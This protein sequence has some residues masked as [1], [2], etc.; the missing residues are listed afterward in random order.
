MPDFFNFLIEILKS[1]VTCNNSLWTENKADSWRL[2]D[3]S[4]DGFFKVGTIVT[5][6]WTDGID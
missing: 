2:W 5:K 1:F 3:P 6:H 4:I